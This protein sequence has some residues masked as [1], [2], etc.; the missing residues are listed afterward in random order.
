MNVTIRIENMTTVE[1]NTIASM[2]SFFTSHQS[3]VTSHQ[4]LSLS[5]IPNRAAEVIVRAHQERNAPQ[6]MQPLVRDVAFPFVAHGHGADSDQAPCAHTLR[7]R[8]RAVVEIPNLVV[9]RLFVHPLRRADG[10]HRPGHAHG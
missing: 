4:S 10:V 9:V 5:P 6:R 1:T 2:S 8:S 3:P 7:R